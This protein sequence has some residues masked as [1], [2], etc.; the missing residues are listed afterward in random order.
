VGLV[1]SIVSLG[2]SIVGVAL[3]NDA[4][5]DDKAAAER[6]AAAIDARLGDGP[7]KA[8]LDRDVAC[9]LVEA[10][11]YREGR[12][13]SRTSTSTGSTASASSRRRATA[14]RSTSSA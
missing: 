6:H 11:V 12:S 3:L 9:G 10:H 1:L 4:I 2:T 14:P 7:S 13:A 8:E 5:E